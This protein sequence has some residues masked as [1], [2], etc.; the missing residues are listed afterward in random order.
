MQ[1]ILDSAINMQQL[2]G[3]MGVLS[4]LLGITGEQSRKG[5][6]FPIIH[7]GTDIIFKS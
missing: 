6:D 5:E 7:Q 2:Q 1:I 4:N 3:G